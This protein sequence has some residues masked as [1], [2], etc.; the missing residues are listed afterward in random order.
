MPIETRLNRMFQ[1]EQEDEASIKLQELLAQKQERDAMI[2]SMPAQPDPNFGATYTPESTAGAGD[3]NSQF[4]QILGQKQAQPEE[5]DKDAIARQMVM[6]EPTPEE[7]QVEAEKEDIVRKGLLEEYDRRMGRVNLGRGLSKF[8][9]RMGG[10]EQDTSGW[11]Q[12]AQRAGMELADYDA[13][14]GTVATKATAGA[15]VGIKEKEL[16]FKYLREKR[17]AA[18]SAVDI[19]MKE[20]QM[21]Q[22]KAA[23]GKDNNYL[24]AAA[25]FKNRKLDLSNINAELGIAEKQKEL[26]KWD[27]TYS[28]TKT[29]EEIANDQATIDLSISKI[30]KDTKGKQLSYMDED[31]QKKFFQQSFKNN[32]DE[33]GMTLDEAQYAFKELSHIEKMAWD[34]EKFYASQ[35]FDLEKLAK[36]AKDEGTK[37]EV[38]ERYKWLASP[39]LKQAYKDRASYEKINHVMQ[40]MNAGNGTLGLKDISLLYSYMSGLDDSI[41]RPSE[42]EMFKQSLGFVQNIANKPDQFAQGAIMSA[43]MRK[44]IAAAVADNAAASYKRLRVRTQDSR[45]FAKSHDLTENNTYSPAIYNDFKTAY[46]ALVT[47]VVIESTLDPTGKPIKIKRTFKSAQAAKAAIEAAKKLNSKAIYKYDV[48]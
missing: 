32:M 23:A 31:R 30:M 7:A 34:R 3:I 33:R 25:E 24:A 47:H 27:E 42:A 2:A 29:K 14:Q 37:L 45:D 36:S 46:D 10:F 13:T 16:A 18:E 28:R 40:K 6:Q 41:V 11:D 38:S 1:P 4:E 9:S 17:L 22:S 12:K 48:Q 44:A 21:E 20:M 5:P 8:Y 19:S 35:K 43:K 39:E 15:Y 26:G